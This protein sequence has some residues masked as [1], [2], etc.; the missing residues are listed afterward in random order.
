M[1]SATE[2]RLSPDPA[3]HL[4]GRYD[5]V[6]AAGI[7]RVWENVLDWEH[8]PALHNGQFQS[9]A[10]LDNGPWGWRAR[11]VNHPGD[12]SKAQT[13]AVRIDRA[14]GRYCSA[15]LEG[16][17]A[18]TEIWTT[19][20]PQGPDRTAV[21]VTFHVAEARPER[22]A[23]IGARYVEIYARLWDEDEAMMVERE[24]AL[25]ARRTLSR[26]TVAVL[27][28]GPVEAVRATL[29]RLVEV[30]GERFRLLELDGQ[31]IAHAAT[32]P[33]WLGP[34]GAAPV[35]DG[36]IR[37]PWHD[38]AFDVL[39]GASTDGRGLSLSPAPQVLLERGDVVI[40]R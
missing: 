27:N 16:P 35:V 21:A 1:P 6:V 10:L 31:L 11:V 20:T 39:T 24:R 9:I 13:I 34:L 29:P 32:C 19:L 37:C 26:D 7:A 18:G 22:L 30:G 23:G 17:G 40:R 8:L 4:A 36:C 14:A 15:T 12:E 28:L 25:A 33:H 3:L 2:T 38:Y 5:R